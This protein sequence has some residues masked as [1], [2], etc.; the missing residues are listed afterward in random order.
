MLPV[1]RPPFD[2]LTVVISPLIAL[3]KDQVDGLL[4][5]G[6][7]ATFINSSLSYNE[8][9]ARRRSLSNKE[10]KIPLYRT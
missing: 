8:I 5:D 6:I 10:T 3:M 1:A 2:G 4:A 9:E 7:P